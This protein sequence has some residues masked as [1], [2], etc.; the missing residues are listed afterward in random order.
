M[1]HPHNPFKLPMYVDRS[2]ANCVVTCRLAAVPSAYKRGQGV[3]GCT[4]PG[5]PL[6]FFRQTRGHLRPMTTSA[7]GSPTLHCPIAAARL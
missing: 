3:Q 5:H 4:P 7:Y 6:G 2:V 1:A